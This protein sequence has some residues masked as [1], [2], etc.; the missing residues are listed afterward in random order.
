MYRS[1]CISIRSDKGVKTKSLSMELER[2]VEGNIKMTWAVSYGWIHG[3]T[4]SCPSV[5][6]RIHTC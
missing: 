2:A 6:S 4:V 3:C 1:N 5:E